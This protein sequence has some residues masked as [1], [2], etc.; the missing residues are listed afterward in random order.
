MNIQPTIEIALVFYF[1]LGCL[2]KTTEKNE[3]SMLFYYF[4]SSFEI[5]IELKINREIKIV[6]HD[7]LTIL[8]FFNRFKLK[9]S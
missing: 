2:R 5:I 9:F 6:L 1:K 4:K 3:F 8:K 7:L